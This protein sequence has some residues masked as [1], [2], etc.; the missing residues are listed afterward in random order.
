MEKT[1]LQVVFE[2]IKSKPMKSNELE[3]STS[4]SKST[5]FRCLKSLLDDG[6]IKNDNGVYKIIIP[7]PSIKDIYDVLYVL[8]QQKLMDNKYRKLKTNG[9]TDELLISYINNPTLLK[10]NI[11]DYNFN[12]LLDNI[13]KASQMLK[14]SI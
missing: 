14:H 12:S 11:E 6:L 9:K 2:I 10:G 13:T 1:N 5:L 7:T 4:I 8:H 3:E